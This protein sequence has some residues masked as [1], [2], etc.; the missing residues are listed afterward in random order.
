[1]LVFLDGSPR[2]IPDNNSQIRSILVLADDDDKYSLFHMQYIRASRLTESTEGAERF[3][4]QD[5]VQW[6]QNQLQIMFQVLYN[7]VHVTYTTTIKHS[8]KT[9]WA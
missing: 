7:E 9:L 4:L 3:A 2:N 1:M 6:L 8:A 5:A